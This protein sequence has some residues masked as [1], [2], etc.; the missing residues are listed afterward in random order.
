MISY[1]DENTGKEL[2]FVSEKY[3][4]PAEVENLKGDFSKAKKNLKWSPTTKL[5]ELVKIMLD[6]DLKYN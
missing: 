3:F 2:I 1:Y 5:K 4:R 6:H